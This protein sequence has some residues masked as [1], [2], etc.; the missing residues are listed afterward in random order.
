MAASLP[1]DLLTATGM[2]PILW[3]S[4]SSRSLLENAI[5]GP[6]MMRAPRNQLW[7]LEV[8]RVSADPLDTNF[9]RG[10]TTLS[11]YITSEQLKDIA[12][13]HVNRGTN[14]TDAVCFVKPPNLGVNIGSRISPV[15]GEV[16]KHEY[17]PRPGQGRVRQNLPITLNYWRGKLVGDWALYIYIISVHAPLYYCRNSICSNKCTDAI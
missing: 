3:L 12:Q 5:S 13:G 16:T 6:E 2:R 11:K 1:N 14:L 10:P 9:T 15:L 4:P 17:A 7:P 8:S